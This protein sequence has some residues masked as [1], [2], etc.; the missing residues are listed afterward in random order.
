[1]PEAA[2]MWKLRRLHARVRRAAERH[3]QHEPIAGQAAIAL[4]LLDSFSATYD[5]LRQAPI[6]WMNTPQSGR[7]A[8]YELVLQARMWMPLAVRDLPHIERCNYLDS[9]ISDDILDDVEWLIASL[10]DGRLHDGQPLAYREHA[11]DELDCALR[12]AQ[13]KWNEAEQQYPEYAQHLLALRTAATRARAG[14]RAFLRAAAYTLTYLS[15][16]YLRLLPSRAGYL[17]DDD[18]RTA[19]Y[20][21]LIEPATLVTGIPQSMELHG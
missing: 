14:L 19:P 1:M 18:D 2:A 21:E 15:P 8:V 9:P 3:A 5:A 17:E 10:R 20:P 11:I 16:E 4:P 7:A 6:P 13:L 12:H